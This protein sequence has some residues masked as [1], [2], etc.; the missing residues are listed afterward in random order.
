M[1]KGDDMSFCPKCGKEIAED[2][3]FCPN[4]G[5]ALKVEQV[6]PQSERA[7]TYRHEKE[8]KGEKGTEKREKHEKREYAF[9]GPLIGGL[10]LV[11]IGLS[12][13]LSVEEA[14]PRARATLWAF[15]FILVGVFII[16]VAAY[17]AMTAQRRHPRT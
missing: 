16:G 1:C 2:M 14:T 12:A 15:F 8:E 5:A 4:C 9:I 13:Y 3:V 11:F 7:R 6:A 10:I 17:A